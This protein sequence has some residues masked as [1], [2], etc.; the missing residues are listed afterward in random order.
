M[1][2]PLLDLKRR[3]NLIKE[4]IDK[5]IEK[6]LNSQH[7]ILGEEV[8]KLEKE[9]AKYC[10]TEYAVAVASGTDALLLSLRSLSIEKGAFVITTPFTFFATAGAIH[11]I[12]ATPIFVDIKPDTFNIDP[13]KTQELLEG[14]TFHTK[15]LKLDLSKI[16]A[17][18][19]IHLY[20]QTAD[21]DPIIEIANKYNLEIIE[22]ACQAIGAEYKSKKAGSLGTSGCFSFFPTKNLGA[23]GDGGIITTYRE[24]VAAELKKLRVHGSEK[25][26]HHLS[27]GYNSRLDTI[28]AA[29]LLTEL[30]HLDDWNKKREENAAIYSDSLKDIEQ[31]D[32]PFVAPRRKHIFH[33]YT[34]RVKNEK[35]DKLRNFLTQKEIGSKIY[36]PTPLHLQECF[37][38]LGYKK[39]DLPHSEKAAAE[40]LSL[41]IF[42]ELSHEEIVYTCESIKSF[43][44]RE[45]N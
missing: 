5:A 22:D 34:I 25:D 31:L 28:Q 43:F 42:P 21:M 39:G 2:V 17:M 14:K 45:N 15:R 1:K 9:I 12:G 7:F 10:G 41:P 40:V 27:V 19:P 20:G 24:E 29:I 4:E 32:R 3:Y 23:Y 18:I 30:P 13:E 8:T 44:G 35:R 36:Y 26:Y 33:Q 11:N 6:V 16:K 37:N 38:Y